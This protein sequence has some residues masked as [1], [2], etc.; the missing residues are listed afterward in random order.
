[1]TKYFNTKKFGLFIKIR[2]IELELSRE[3][4]AIKSGLHFNTIGKIERGKQEIKLRTATQLG[5][6]LDFKISDVIQKY[7]E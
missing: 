5:K 3:E 7:Q 1:M 6:V 2:R 4:L